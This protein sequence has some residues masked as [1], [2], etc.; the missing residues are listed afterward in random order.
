MPIS[1][2]ASGTGEGFKF[3]Q[4]GED[5][6]YDAWFKEQVQIGI[7]EA[8]RDEVISHEEMTLWFAEQRKA[9]L[10]RI[11]DEERSHATKRR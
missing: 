4:P 11:E 1:K 9:L 6:E 10:K 5:L 2:P 3:K 7:H 8:E